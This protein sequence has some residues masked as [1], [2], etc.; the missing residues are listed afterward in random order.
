M[1]WDQRSR[2]RAAGGVARV[3]ADRRG[4]HDHAGGSQHD[5]RAGRRPARRA[6]Q[7]DLDERQP[8]RARADAERAVPWSRSRRIQEHRFLRGGLRRPQRGRRRRG[9]GRRGGGGCSERRRNGSVP[10]PRPGGGRRRAARDADVAG[11]HPGGSAAIHVQRPGLEHVRRAGSRRSDGQQGAR[12][13][14]GRL[15]RE[16]RIGPDR[17]AQFL[18]QLHG[19]AGLI[20]GQRRTLSEPDKRYGARYRI[21]LTGSR[22]DLRV[23]FREVS[24]SE[25]NPPIRLYDTSGFHSD[26]IIPVDVREGLPALRRHWILE[27]G[28]VEEYDGRNA[29]VEGFTGART[30]PLRARG[31]AAV[32]QMAYARRGVITPE[33]EFCALREGLSTDV[34][35]DEVARGRAIIPANVNHPESE[36]MI[37]GRNF[38]VKINAN[39]GNSA[40]SSSIGEE[41]EKMTWAIRFGAD[42][43]MDLSTGK[44]I[45]ETREWIIR[46]SPVPIG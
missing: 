45:H 8:A 42:T 29:P 37:I 9:N 34:I 43:V 21:R 6:D 25:G 35:R 22:D 19:F 14:V 10:H 44:N 46:N 11:R 27:R 31:G 39:I 40:V 33:M 2:A 4:S 7:R 15:L 17:I 13:A 5:L 12:H 32:T 16:R 24:Q 26:P 38:L 30:K 18:A 1:R 3:P 28:D 20:R 41:V 23:P 36:P